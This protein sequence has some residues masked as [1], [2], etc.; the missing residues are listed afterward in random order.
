[1]KKLLPIG[2]VLL[3][4]GGTKSI[5]ITG[6]YTKNQNNKVY[7]YNGCIFPEGYMENL[8]CLFNHDDIKEIY[9]M[10]LDNKEYQDYVKKIFRK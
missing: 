9:Y 3:L 4:N 1:M 2:T 10:G 5:M 7:D 8:F 6:Y